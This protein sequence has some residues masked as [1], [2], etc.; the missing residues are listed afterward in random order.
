MLTHHSIKDAFECGEGGSSRGDIALRYAVSSSCASDSSSDRGS[1][2]IPLLTDHSIVIG[3]GFGR[4][5]DGF[6]GFGLKDE[7]AKLGDVGTN[8]FVSAIGFHGRAPR[9]GRA[10]GVEVEDGGGGV[11]KGVEACSDGG[12]LGFF[13][14]CN[15]G[16]GD[17]TR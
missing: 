17:F 3:G 5:K 7:F 13:A 10:V 1:G 8:P 16:G 4:A 14:R 15:W 2:F 12:G 9:E 11:V 6:E